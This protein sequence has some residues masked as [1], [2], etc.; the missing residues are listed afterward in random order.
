MSVTLPAAGLAADIN[1]EHE[2]AF[3]KAH[4]ALEHARRAG[5]LLLK[6]K[7]AIGHGAWLAWVAEHCDF[8]SRQAQRYMILAE[9]WP[10]LKAKYDTASHLT[11]TGALRL[12]DRRGTTE[13]EKARDL[14]RRFDKLRIEVEL[15]AAA[16]DGILD[17]PNADIN[18]VATI[19]LR[20]MDLEREAVDLRS[21]A[22]RECGRLLIDLKRF[23]RLDDAALLSAVN[24]GSL[25]RACDERLAE[26]EAA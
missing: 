22:M 10:A 23:T 18:T 1:A 11:L 17:D 24:D 9:S 8:S 21:H 25:V 7:A 16:A 19:G 14:E 20:A 5:E 15:L 3:G 6:A 26:L 2:R 13:L 12:I 4:E